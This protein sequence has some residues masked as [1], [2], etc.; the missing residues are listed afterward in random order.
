MAEI[1]QIKK[2][3]EETGAGMLDVKKALEE[4]GDDYDK[5]LEVL[6]KK[7]AAKAAKKS[8]RNAGDGLV[9]SY[10]HAGGKLGV[11]L[12]LYCETDFVA[13]TEEFQKLGEDI[14]MHIAAM[15]PEYLSP[16]DIPE[17]V[18]EAEKKIYKEQVADSGKPENIVEQI[19]EG[20]MQKFAEE[21]SL[22]EQSFVK[23]P[24]TKIKELVES[25]IAKLGEN[26]QVGSFTRY[27]L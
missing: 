7:G 22:L 19:V 26:I 12:K 17:E 4:A 6:R 27:E 20:K 14:A 9:F 16:E 15:S 21:V 1:E 24:D 13:R 25:Y 5:A 23:D 3:R 8:D 10:I 18:K 2:L 11:L